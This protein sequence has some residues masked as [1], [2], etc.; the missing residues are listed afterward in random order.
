MGIRLADALLRLVGLPSVGRG[1]TDGDDGK[2]GNK[3]KTK[4]IENFDMVLM[5]VLSPTPLR[6]S[7]IDTDIF[8]VPPL[9][10]SPGVDPLTV[11]RYHTLENA[12]F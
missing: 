8:L 3:G 6:A 12:R 9:F 10:L 4:R 7:D 1:K 5:D 11:H 2:K